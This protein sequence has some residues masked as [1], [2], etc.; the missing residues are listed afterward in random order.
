MVTVYWLQINM[1]CGILRCDAVCVFRS[2]NWFV[3]ANDEQF[4]DMPLLL[5]L[6]LLHFFARWPNERAAANAF[7]VK[8]VAQK[9]RQ[10]AKRSKK[11]NVHCVDANAAFIMPV[12][13]VQ[14]K[15]NT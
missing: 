14:L 11:K 13:R 8:T 4:K 10:Q 1:E 15:T 7:N 3:V 5:E 9:C 12:D 2:A 6:Q